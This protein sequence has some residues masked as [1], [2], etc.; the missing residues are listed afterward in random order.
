MSLNLCTIPL[1]LT[2]LSTLEDNVIILFTC[3]FAR[4]RTQKVL[5][6]WDE[7]SSVSPCQAYTKMPRFRAPALLGMRLP[8][9]QRFFH[10]SSMHNP[11]VRPSFIRYL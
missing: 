4:R 6:D 3:L 8:E 10:T 11:T 9:G 5:R 7:I 1:L 2:P